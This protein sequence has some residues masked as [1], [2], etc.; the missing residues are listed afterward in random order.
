MEKGDSGGGLI[1]PRNTSRNEDQ[2]FIYGILSIKDSK[3]RGLAIFTDL[4]FHINWL[5]TSVKSI[6]DGRR[7]GK[8]EKCSQMQTFTYLRVIL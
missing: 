6:V 8:L 2:Y 3:T 7:K 4:G 5:T 1:F